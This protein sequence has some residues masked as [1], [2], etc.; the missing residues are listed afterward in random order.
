MHIP[1]IRIFLALSII[2]FC[3]PRL[4]AEDSRVIPMDYYLIIDGSQSFQGSKAGAISWINEQVV[5]RLLMDGDRVTILVAGD[6]AEVVFSGAVSGDKGAIKD[7]LANLSTTG[8]SADFSG[9]LRNVN[10]R[11]SGAG[12][13]TGRLS[14][15]MLITASADG[16]ERAIAGDT[17]GLL[18]WFRTEKYEQWQVLI[19]APD[20]GRRV[21]Q[22]A[23]AYM[24]SL[25][26]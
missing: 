20:I 25:R 3:L 13:G 15:T 14:Y 24:N 26:R 1:K 16:L 4:D 8:R 12:G 17:Q 11:I 5:D 10:T 18:R 6:S 2:A 19:V 7:N 23:A 21:N 22:A 9:A